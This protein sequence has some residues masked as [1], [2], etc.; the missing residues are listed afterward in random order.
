MLPARLRNR[1]QVT[2][3]AANLRAPARLLK[4]PRPGPAPDVAQITL[5]HRHEWGTCVPSG[6][7]TTVAVAVA[8]GAG[9]VAFSALPESVLP[10]WSRAEVCACAGIPFIPGVGETVASA[11]DRGETVDFRPVDSHW[12]ARGHA[13]AAAVLDAWLRQAGLPR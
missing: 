12:N 13:I 1:L 5:R 2:D 3:I 11:A 7:M 4:P 8:A 10:F 9:A 6:R